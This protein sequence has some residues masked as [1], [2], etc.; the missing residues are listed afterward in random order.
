MI[1]SP[2]EPVS[3]HWTQTYHRTM[4][5]GALTEHIWNRNV[6]RFLCPASHPRCP[7]D[8]AYCLAASM[9]ESWDNRGP[10]SNSTE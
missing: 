9:L 1:L 2:L 8:E 5:A 6:E 4:A 3:K 10:Q 7:D